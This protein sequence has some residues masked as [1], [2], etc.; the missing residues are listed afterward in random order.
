MSE[1]KDRGIMKW[2]P[3]DA[4]NGHTAIIEEMI[5]NLNKKQKRIIS[6]DDFDEFN[7]FYVK[8]LKEFNSIPNLQKP[9]FEKIAGIENIKKELLKYKD[10]DLAINNFT[11]DNDMHIKTYWVTVLEKCN[12]I[13]KKKFVV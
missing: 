9:S 4:L 5:F 13:P 1:Y 11:I 2:A 6:T 12:T 8:I 3:F 10:L 7:A